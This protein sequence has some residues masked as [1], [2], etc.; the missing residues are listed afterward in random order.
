MDF[1]DEDRAGRRVWIE[2]SERIVGEEDTV[3][4][5]DIERAQTLAAWAGAARDFV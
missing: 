4:F 5:P 1:V 2:S 3:L